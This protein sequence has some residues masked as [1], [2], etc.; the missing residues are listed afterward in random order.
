MNFS[1]SAPLIA[2]YARRG[3]RFS[4]CCDKFLLF[5]MAVVKPFRGVMYNPA[6]V[7]DLGM[8]FCPPFDA[9]SPQLEEELLKTV[10]VQYC[11]VGACTSG[12]GG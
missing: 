4:R 3:A 2:G 10:A 12:G 6:V 11:E 5:R 7:G 1:K 8:N 9:M